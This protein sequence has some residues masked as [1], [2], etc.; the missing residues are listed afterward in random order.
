M[1]C[2][3]DIK[4]DAVLVLFDIYSVENGIEMLGLMLTLMNLTV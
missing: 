3:I 2:K 1:M 4:N